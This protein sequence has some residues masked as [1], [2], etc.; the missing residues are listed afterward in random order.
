MAGMEITKTEVNVTV[1]D[2][3][4]ELTRLAY[5]GKFKTYA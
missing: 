3:A 1:G 5:P 2:R 4:D